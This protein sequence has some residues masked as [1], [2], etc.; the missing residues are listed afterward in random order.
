MGVDELHGEERIEVRVGERG[1]A[2]TKAV[3]RRSATRGLGQLRPLLEKHPKAFD[4]EESAA[5]RSHEL[6]LETATDPVTCRRSN[7]GTAGLQSSV[8]HDTSEMVDRA[9]MI[10]SFV[11][12]LTFGRPKVTTF[13]A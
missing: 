11:W 4:L 3:Q 7:L 1:A 6:E 2:E 9:L 13:E 5:T 8:T 10:G 12:H